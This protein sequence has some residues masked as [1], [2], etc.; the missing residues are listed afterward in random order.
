ML[1][2]A[3]RLFA[4]FFM[5]NMLGSCARLAPKDPAAVY[6]HLVAVP[7]ALPSGEDTAPLLQQFKRE[8][9]ARAGG[10]TQLGEAEGGWIDPRGQLLTER[11]HLFLICSPEDLSPA[12]GRDLAM[13]FKQ[14]LPFVLVWPARWPQ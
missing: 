12:L 8:W 2:R 5:L 1:L 6:V 7:K 14:E 3:T 11:N 4:L 10:Y 9:S 13:R